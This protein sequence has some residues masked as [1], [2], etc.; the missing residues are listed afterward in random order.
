MLISLYGTIPATGMARSSAWSI[1]ARLILDCDPPEIEGPS[2]DEKW[3]VMSFHLQI[4]RVNDK[5]DI[6]V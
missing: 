6:S 5:Q 4:R 3:G 2:D 1:C